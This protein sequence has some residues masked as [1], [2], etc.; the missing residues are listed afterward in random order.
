MTDTGRQGP[1]RDAAALAVAVMAALVATGCGG[2]GGGDSPSA[3]S[4]PATTP[5]TGPVTPPVTTPVTTPDPTPVTP[6]VTTLTDP[7]FTY[8]WHLA[9]SGQDALSSTRPVPGVDLN[10]GGLHA[11]GVRGAGVRVAIVDSGLD[12]RHEDLQANVVAGAS[13]NFLNNSGDPTPGKSDPDHGTAVA[14][15]VAARGW[16]GVGGRGVAPEARLQGFNFMA[17]QNATNLALAL[18][19]SPLTAATQVFNLS[20]GAETLDIAPISVNDIQTLDQFFASTRSNRGGIYV[21]SAGNSFLEMANVDCSLAQRYGVGCA[22]SNFETVFN[23]SAI[24]VVGAVNAAG[25]RSSYSTPGASVLVAGLGGE[26]GGH[27]NQ[28]PGAQEVMYQPA[29][30]TTD[31]SG[32]DKGYHRNIGRSINA[33]DVVGPSPLDPSCNYTAIF[34]GTSAAAPS[35]SGVVAMMLQVNPALTQREVQ[36]ILATTARRVDYPGT[37]VK[38]EG[39]AIDDAWVVNGASRAF[40]NTFGFGLVDA[41]A[42]VEAARR[43]SGLSVPR[44]SSWLSARPTSPEAIPYRDGA[45]TRGSIPIAVNDPLTVETV[46][47]SFSTTHRDPAKLRVT[48]ISPSGTRSILVW[49]FSGLKPLAGTTVAGFGSDLMRSNAFLDEKAQGTWRLEVVDVSAPSGTSTSQFTHWSLRIAG[50]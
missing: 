44:Q 24:T 30:L 36:Y 9:N 49:P 23:L 28:A 25:K 39:V 47:V 3:A 14:G 18:G 38:F 15:I 2:G 1:R 8:Q 41:G 17:A 46:Q 48:L 34:Y 33:L 7:L 12:I 43:G 20:F 10:V 16:N 19:V 31:L 21:K 11:T 13:I 32:C 35:V 26:A 42:A 27:R 6:P 29:V 40:S 4:P 22:N 50:R 5:V 45:G 37:P